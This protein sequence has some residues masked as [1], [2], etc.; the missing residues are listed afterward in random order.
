[1]FWCWC[2]FKKTVCNRYGFSRT[3]PTKA[4]QTRRE[5]AIG[6][7][8]RETI[9]ADRKDFSIFMLS[10]RLCVS[11][12]CLQAQKKRPHFWGHDSKE[13]RVMEGNVRKG[14]ARHRPAN[15]GGSNGDVE[16]NGE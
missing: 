2:C 1:M 3:V 15:R 10:L 5:A 7:Q 4:N 9:K 13:A 8:G 6:T 11:V 14:D 16:N 12:V